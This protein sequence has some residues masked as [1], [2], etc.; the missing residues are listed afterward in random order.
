VSTS[1]DIRPVLFI[2]SS[3]ECLTVARAVQSL[4]DH[5]ADVEVWTDGIFDIGGTVLGSLVAKATEVDFAVMV[6]NSDDTASVRGQSRNIAG[7]T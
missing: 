6:V 3:A 1:T 4:L 2:G 7:T 5:D